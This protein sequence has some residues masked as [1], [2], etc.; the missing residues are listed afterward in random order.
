LSRIL[1]VDDN[2][3]VRQAVSRDLGDRGFFPIEASDGKKALEIF[4]KERPDSVLLDL[5][6][7]GMG[8]IETL[9]KFK[10]IDPDIPIVIVTGHGDI[11]TAVEAIK[12]GA[13][14][15]VVKPPDFDRLILTLRRAVEKYE[16]D[17]KIKMLSSDVRT[18]LEYL[19]GKGDAM[20]KVIQDVH[21]ISHSDFSLVIQGETGTG[22]SF[23]ARTIHNL[24]KRA[25]CPFVSVDI[26]SI[27]ETLIESE[28]FGYEKGAFTGAEKKKKGFFEIADRGTLVIDEMQNMSPYVQSKL[29]MAAEEKNIIPLGSTCPIKT[30]VRIIGATNTDILKSV[31][32]EKGFREDLFYRLGEF[33]I[34][35]PP[36][37]ERREDIPA[38]ADK[39][40]MEAAED[41]NK[42]MHSISEAA[43]NL[44]E[45]YSWP[46]NIRE[47]K[48]VVRR[49][50]LLSDDG[51]VKPGNI[52]FLIKYKEPRTGAAHSAFD[53]PPVLDLKKIEELTI[54]KALEVTKGNKSKAAALLN[55]SYVT[56]FKKIKDYSIY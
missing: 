51:I 7:P 15:F 13:Y 33:M 27:P 56:L 38:F 6:M 18:S 55:I 53:G 36:L 47:L 39:F 48:N 40:L 46:G 28:L 4:Q 54:K 50:V 1:V 9:Q 52:E 3:T 19:L 8:G 43:M 34:F 35:L 14:E 20:K 10:E 12:L 29:L 31:K 16:L 17:R 5:Q 11:P 23:V 44:L 25:N 45:E 41:L 22:K 26:G 30:D 2:K 49:A 24:S 37:R 42:P 32:E 21:R